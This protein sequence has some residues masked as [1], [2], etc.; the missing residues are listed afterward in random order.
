MAEFENDLR[1]EHQAEGIA[2]AKENGVNFGQ[3]AKLT[4]EKQ[5]WLRGNIVFKVLV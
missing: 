4:P 3:P 2:K 5:Y 1:T